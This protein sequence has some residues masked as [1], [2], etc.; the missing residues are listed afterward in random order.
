MQNTH[1]V[2]GSLRE[3]KNVCSLLTEWQ[4]KKEEK[5]AVSPFSPPFLLPAPL[6]PLRSHHAYA[7]GRKAKRGRLGLCWNA[8]YM[9][10]L[11]LSFTLGWISDRER[12][13][14]KNVVWPQ[15]LL[16]DPPAGVEEE[17]IKQQSCLPTRH[18]GQDNIHGQVCGGRR[19]CFSGYLRTVCDFPFFLTIFSLGL[20]QFLLEEW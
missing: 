5:Q 20:W 8:T 6:Q 3:V 1:A 11:T 15:S 4:I 14:M 9:D 18:H 16:P 2:C 19:K 12:R 13:A 17:L 10:L 7:E